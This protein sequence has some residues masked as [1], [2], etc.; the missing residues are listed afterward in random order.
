MPDNTRYELTLRLR[1]LGAFEP[2]R[3]CA[4]N[5]SNNHKKIHTATDWFGYSIRILDAQGQLQA[6]YDYRH[7]PEKLLKLFL[8]RR[9]ER[10]Q[11]EPFSCFIQSI[12]HEIYDQ[13][14]MRIHGTPQT[15][16]VCIRIIVNPI[17]NL[18]NE[19][20][21]CYRARAL[22]HKDFISETAIMPILYPQCPVRDI[23]HES[24]LWPLATIN[25]FFFN[26]HHYPNFYLKSDEDPYTAA[27]ILYSDNTHNTV[28][29]SHQNVRRKTSERHRLKSTFSN[30]F[31]TLP[32]ERQKRIYLEYK[33]YPAD[34]EIYDITPRLFTTLLTRF[35]ALQTQTLQDV[36][37]AAP[38]IP[39]PSAQGD[40]CIVSLHREILSSEEESEEDEGE[41]EPFTPSKDWVSGV[42]LT[43]PQSAPPAEPEAALEE[44]SAS[45]QLAKYL[46]QEVKSA[47]V[48]KIAHK[49]SYQKQTAQI[50]PYNLRKK[51]V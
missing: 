18:L 44:D 9:L 34:F 16:G 11:T 50:K 20:T 47:P 42:D 33:T 38:N 49:K 2:L 43:T 14:V 51:H 26:E 6:F 12:N 19:W 7:E 48:G 28:A 39:I 8:T 4:P 40:E 31:L 25:Q 24:G 1:H 32:Y 23:P 10:G 5:G 35:P 36:D 13:A 21:S 45:L 37:D 30:Q 46:T 17:K 27:E 41:P 22:A 15:R 29:L 3:L